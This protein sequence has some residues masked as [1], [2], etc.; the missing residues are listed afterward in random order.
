MIELEFLRP[1]HFH[2][3]KRHYY[4]S[5][6]VKPKSNQQNKTCICLDGSE[7]VESVSCD[8]LFQGRHN[9]HVYSSQIG[10]P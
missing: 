9:T 3:F 2:Q 1:G 5:T 4:Y 6:E 7:E 10:I 8:K